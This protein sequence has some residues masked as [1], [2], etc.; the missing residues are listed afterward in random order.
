MN[1]TK[2]FAMLAV[3]VFIWGL[4]SLWDY[5]YESTD[6]DEKKIQNSFFKNVV[7]LRT[8]VAVVAAM[9]AG[10]MFYSLTINAR[11]LVSVMPQYNNPNPN[12]NPNPYPNPNPGTDPGTGGIL[13]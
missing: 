13:P 1:S 2:F 6:K 4:A 11:D 3:A 12:P 7:L 8:A 10:Y 9:V 5:L